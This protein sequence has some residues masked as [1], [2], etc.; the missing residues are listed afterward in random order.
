MCLFMNEPLGFIVG[1][2]HIYA[3][4]GSFISTHVNMSIYVVQVL[5]CILDSICTPTYK[6]LKHELTMRIFK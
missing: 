5:F 6:N 3:C 2:A 1:T 4:T